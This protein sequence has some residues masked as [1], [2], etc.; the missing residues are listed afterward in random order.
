MTSVVRVRIVLTF[1]ALI[2]TAR[3][4]AALDLPAP[5]RAPAPPGTSTEEPPPVTPA[6]PA[7]DPQHTPRPPGGGGFGPG[8]PGGPG[9]GGPPGY[10][11]A[12]YP[13]RPVS[14][15]PTDLGFLRQGLSVAAPVWC[16]GGDVVMV[17]LGVRNTL[18]STDAV[19][20]D[21]LR[22]FP[23]QLWNLNLGVN[24]LHRF[25]NGWTAAV[26]AGFGSASDKPFHSIA[27]M[28]ANLGAFLRVPAWDGRDSWQVGLMY[29]AGGPAN[30]PIPILSYAWNPS[31]RLRVNVG[32]P[33]S[34]FWQPTDDLTVNLSYVPLLNVNARLTYRLSP[35]VQV[36]GGY[37][38]LNE[39]YLLADRT[40]VLDRFFAFEQRVVTGLR[41][42][43]GAHG[44]LELNG[45][46]SFGRTYGEGQ[47]QLGSLSDR[48]NVDPGPFL[49]FS[50]RFRF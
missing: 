29:V 13:S 49:G 50:C 20:P 9:A 26:I 11:A 14:G 40:D 6:D 4:V 30:F 47:N 19:L 21:S 10:D 39:S 16:D 5:D 35:R 44:T 36:Y 45:G 42:E 41:W 15:Q 38:F 27:E 37:E 34:V 8:G 17:S 25:D 2:L 18:F 23:R 3:G 22:P 43:V 32:L 1:L 12:W 31:D 28:T 48:V 24:Y 33:L 46:Y 7:P